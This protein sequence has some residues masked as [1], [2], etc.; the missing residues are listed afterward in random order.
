MNETTILTTAA[1]LVR[2]NRRPARAWQRAL[3]EAIRDP[4]EL[5]RILDLPADYEAAAVRAAEDFPLVV[6]R[7]Y[8]GR[9]RRGDP[10][11]PLLRQ[12]LPLDAERADPAGFA[13][14]PVGDAS[15][16]LTPGL[17]RKYHGRAL[18]VTTGACA[19]HCR[20][21]FRR[22]YPYS[23]LPHS[24]DAWEPA[25]KHIAGDPSLDEVLLSGGDPL[26]W[27]D[28]WLA[29][30]VHRLAAIPHLRR[31]RVHTRLPIVIPERVCDELLDWLRGTRLAT[32]VVVH[33][34]HPAELDDAVAGALG[35]LVD[36]GVVVLNQSVLLRGVNDQSDV[37]VELCRRLVDLR[38]MPYYLHQL[39]R[40]RGAAHFEVP[41][42]VGV[43][44]VAEMR[45]RLPGYAVPR[46][47][48]EVAGEQ[49]KLVLA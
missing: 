25:L 36:A 17:L 40:V 11:D 48:R 1:D 43:E 45:K 2:P 46:Y 19:V 20:Y 27:V 7:G 8:A 3:R 32:V 47:V 18:M 34:N 44:L 22:Q 14:D 29:R 13:S 33:A 31:L 6:P 23:D 30:L 9:I 38:V 49:H 24:L 21:C 39:D 10:R 26:T 42:E 35:R 4:R 28:D 16:A 37:L 15:A 41:V 5:C 12:V